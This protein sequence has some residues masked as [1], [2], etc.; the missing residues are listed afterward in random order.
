MSWDAKWI[1]EFEN[2]LLAATAENDDEKTSALAAEILAEMC[3]QEDRC[4]DEPARRIL[5]Q[6]RRNRR[7][8]L[9]QRLADQL[10]QSGSRD[11]EIRRQYAQSQL[12]Q[13]NITAG[14]SVLRQLVR[15]TVGDDWRENYEARG[16]L[17]RA[18]KQLY[19]DHGE[20][21][22]RRQRRYLQDALRWYHGVYREDS[23]QLWHG[24]NTVAL[25]ARAERDGVRLD[26][27][28]PSVRGL[29]EAI[30]S[31][32]HR[33]H[34][35]GRCQVWDE[36]TALEACVALG[37]PEEALTWLARYLDHREDEADA[38]EYASTHRQLTEVWQLDATEGLGAKI[39]PP[40]M[41]R[42][43]ERQGGRLEIASDE[44]V[45][46]QKQAIELTGDLQYERILGRDSFVR[47]RWLASA[48]ERA[49][50]VARIENRL[51]GKGIGTGFL[52]RG[53]DFHPDYG[54]EILLLTN[55]HVLSDIATIHGAL[56]ARR[57]LV[58]FEAPRPAI[59]ERR[60]KEILWS[61]P[62]HELDG[63]LA[64][65]DPPIEELEA[66]PITNE[67]PPVGDGANSRVYVIGHPR[68]GQLSFSIHDNHLLDHDDR[69]LHYRAPTEGGSS[70]SPVFNDQWELVALHHAGGEEVARLNDKAGY[71]AAN[72]GIW[73]QAI[74]R[75]LNQR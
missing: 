8:D 7:F 29:A 69:L 38:F 71:Y 23:D 24:I 54:D 48:L 3:R 16:L 57:A 14:L 10:L 62:P 66:C 58:T 1:K 65:L 70:G 31:T 75:A 47:L 35:A 34:E 17:G 11:P 59:D 53:G 63:T 60:V 50:S 40:L 45:A 25:L 21:G 36:A 46:Q 28:Y 19:V 61:S 44:L 52:V 41:A 22:T 33:K 42:L 18:Y 72:E 6:L 12:D 73:V 68:G 20:A 5:K 2:R 9:M 13:G 26:G 56:S 27:G 67:L 49:K 64:R 4:P 37:R 51:T 74:A 30:L 43:L 39:L 55:A 32:V 15:S